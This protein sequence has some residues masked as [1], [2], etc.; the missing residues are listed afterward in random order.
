H[1]YRAVVAHRDPMVMI[2]EDFLQPGEAEHMIAVAGPQMQRSRV[3][4][5]SIHSE[6]RTSS[7][8]YLAKTADHV[9]KCIEERASLVSNITVA[10]TEPLQVVWYKEGQEFRPHF[11]YVSTE[12]LKRDYWTRFGQRYVTILVYLNEPTEGG[13]TIFPKLGLDFAPKKN[14]AVFWYNVGLN[15]R[16]DERTLHG[17]APVKGGEKYAINIWQRK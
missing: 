1:N 16:E 7:S 3:F 14:A 6:A 9:I 5:E 8:A 10:D 13:S 11:D 17:G 15:D 4:G 12:D 2:L